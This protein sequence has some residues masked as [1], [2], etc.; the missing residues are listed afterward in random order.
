MKK[1]F[2]LTLIFAASLVADDD[3]YFF[4]SSSG[5]KPA[6][7]QTYLNECTS[8]HFGFQPGFLPKR[9]WKKMMGNLENHFGSDA[10]LDEKERNHILK[11]LIENS[12]DNVSGYKRSTKM[13]SSISRYDTPLKI[14]D[15]PYFKREHREIPKRFITQKEVGSLSNCTACHTTAAKGVYSE[16]AIKIPNY[17]RWDD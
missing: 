13:N 4:K 3:Y 10:S 7:D 12:A 2:L 16:R 9:S 14:T 8:C 1:I 17:G 6:T 11:Y 15:V 5:V